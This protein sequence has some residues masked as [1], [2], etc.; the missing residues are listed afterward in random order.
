MVIVFVPGHL[1]N[2]MEH[3]L[4]VDNAVQVLMIVSLMW[5]LDIIGIV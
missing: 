4:H 3:A 1:I 2:S 5:V